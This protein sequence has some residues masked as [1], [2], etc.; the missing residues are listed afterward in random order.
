MAGDSAKPSFLLLGDTQGD[1]RSTADPAPPSLWLWESHLCSSPGHLFWGIST[2]FGGLANSN[3]HYYLSLL[4]E[5][6]GVDLAWQVSPDPGHVYLVEAEKLMLM[7]RAES[8]HWAKDKAP[9]PQACGR[10][11]R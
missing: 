6:G 1:P 11:G 2:R 5:D 10:E 3:G 8:S 4:G 7:I 9:A